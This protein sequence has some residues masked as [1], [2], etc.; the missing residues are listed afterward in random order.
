[1]T[2]DEGLSLIGK[3]HPAEPSFDLAGLHS[4]FDAASR[5]ARN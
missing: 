5:W 4:G 2:L 3:L 1:M